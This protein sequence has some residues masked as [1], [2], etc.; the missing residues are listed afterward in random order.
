ML[1]TYKGPKLPLLV[2]QVRGRGGWVLSPA[3]LCSQQAECFNPLLTHLGYTTPP[4][5]TVPYP[6]LLCCAAS[7]RKAV[8]PSSPLTLPCCYPQGAADNFITQLMPQALEAAAKE[9]GYPIQLRM[10]PGYDHSYF[11]VS[12]FID[13]HIAHHA[14]ELNK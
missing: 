5:H 1:R 9:A 4:H 3:V 14:A 12:S 13:D 7:E 11:F 10:Q 6:I 2:D 8:H